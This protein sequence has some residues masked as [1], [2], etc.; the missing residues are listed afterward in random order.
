MA[1][2]LETVAVIPPVIAAVIYSRMILGTTAGIGPRLLL[3]F[4]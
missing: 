1:L 4:L 2:S 3:G